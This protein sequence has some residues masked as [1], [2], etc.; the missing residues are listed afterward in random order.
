MKAILTITAFLISSLPL[1]SYDTILEDAQEAYDQKDTLTAKR[2]WTEAAGRG[3]AA[4]KVALIKNFRLPEAQAEEFLYSAVESGYEPALD[5]LLDYS[6]GLGYTNKSKILTD[7]YTTLK[8]IDEAFQKHRLSSKQEES[9]AFIK[10]L[11]IIPSL[12]RDSLISLYPFLKEEDFGFAGNSYLAYEA[13]QGGRFGKSDMLL[14]A[15]FLKKEDWFP[16]EPDTVLAY[17]YAHLNDSIV[18]FNPC[19][20]ALNNMLQKVCTDILIYYERILIGLKYDSIKASNP[21]ITGKI[22]S[23]DKSFSETL[24][25]KAELDEIKTGNHNWSYM[26]ALFFIYEDISQYNS[27]LEDNTV[28]NDVHWDV[29]DNINFEVSERLLNFVYGQISEELNDSLR[30]GYSTFLKM[31]DVR[32]MQRAWLRYRNHATE[33]LAKI[34]A[35][36]DKDYI[37]AVLNMRQ[38]EYLSSLLS[39]IIRIKEEYSWEE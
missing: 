22:D 20:Y 26:Q 15:Q 30:T 13:N 9:I 10:K 14:T 38:F 6:R 29:R 2:L 34:H 8:T 18:E 3:S 23:M 11:S 1:F 37:K 19:D 33:A 35:L 36:D 32:I 21:D 17:Y 12:N 16:I 25:K 7:D 39:S 31:E 28:F 27:D 5:M 4:A 24:E